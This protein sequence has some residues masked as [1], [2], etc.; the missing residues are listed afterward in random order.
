MRKRPSQARVDAF[1]EGFD[2]ATTIVIRAARRNGKDSGEFR[3][4]CRLIADLG[5]ERKTP[6]RWWP[7][8]A[9]AK[10]AQQ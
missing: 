3:V 1:F 4:L 2:A 10:E 7:D 8:L 6:D 5:S 9:E